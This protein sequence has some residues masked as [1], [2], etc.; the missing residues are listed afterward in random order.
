MT[1]S[2]G[3]RR[4]QRGDQEQV[5]QAVEH[6]LLAGLLLDDLGREQRHDRTVPLVGPEHDDRRQRVQEPAA[7]SPSVW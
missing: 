7:A 5:E 3:E 4:A 2:D 6:H 1:A